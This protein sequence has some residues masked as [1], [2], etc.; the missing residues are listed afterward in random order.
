M[1]LQSKSKQCSNIGTAGD[2]IWGVILGA[3]LKR[4]HWHRPS[5]FRVTDKRPLGS[6]GL[7]LCPPSSPPVNSPSKEGGR[8]WAVADKC[9]YLKNRCLSKVLPLIHKIYVMYLF[10][11]IYFFHSHNTVAIWKVWGRNSLSLFLFMWH[12]CKNSSEKST[13]LIDGEKKLTKYDYAN[14]ESEQIQIHKYKNWG[15]RLRLLCVRSPK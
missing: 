2:W 13:I 4:Q 8:W 9:S 3:A 7:P 1:K 12:W 5:A 11:L 6:L 14:T 10:N 15:P